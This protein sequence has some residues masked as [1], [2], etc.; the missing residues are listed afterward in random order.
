MTTTSKGGSSY[1]SFKDIKEN[2][3]NAAL[4]P[5]KSTDPEIESI[6]FWPEIHLAAYCRS[7]G[8]RKNHAAIRQRCTVSGNRQ[9]VFDHGTRFYLNISQ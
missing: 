9:T 3:P 5:A 7:I 4:H 1:F 6:P 2:Y 8:K